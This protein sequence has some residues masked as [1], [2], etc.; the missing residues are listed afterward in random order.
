MADLGKNFSNGESPHPLLVVRSLRLIN[1]ASNGD[2]NTVKR[3]HRRAA[4]IGATGSIDR[5][6]G[7]GGV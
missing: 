5:A 2:Y 4:I 6:A 1:A 3:L 7:N